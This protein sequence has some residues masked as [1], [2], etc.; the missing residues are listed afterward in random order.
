MTV[1]HYVIDEVDRG[2][3]ILV[4]YVN[5]KSGESLEDL[6]ERT[7]EVEHLII[8]KGTGLATVRLWE[9][10]RKRDVGQ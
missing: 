6:T 4:K 10:R 5:F 2:E 7:H 3:P 1:F 8:V 9:D